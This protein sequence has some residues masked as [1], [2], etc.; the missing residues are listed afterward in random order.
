MLDEEVQSLALAALF[1]PRMQA[2]QETAYVIR[3]VLFLIPIFVLSVISVALL[4]IRTITRP[5]QVLMRGTQAVS[6]GDLMYRVETL[7]QD[8]FGE[9]AVHFN[10]MV[11]ELQATTVSKA[12]LQESE[13]KLHETV[14]ELRQEITARERTEAERAQLQ[15]SLRRSEIMAAM[16]SLVA[17]VAHE[18]RNPLFAISSTLDAFEVR[19][20]ARQEYQR[21]SSVFRTEVQRLT[22]LMQALL[23]YGK[24]PKLD[25]V[26]DAPGEAYAQAL[27]SCTPLATRMNVHIVSPA[28]TDSRLIRMDRQ[29]L[30]QV[31]QNLMENAIQHSL[32][33]GCIVVEATE[34]P[35]DGRDWISYAIKDSGPGFNPEDLP[36]VFEPF[37]TRRRGGTGLGMSIV[38]R[39]VEEHGGSIVAGN[40]PEGGAVIVVRFALIQQTVMEGRD[41][42]AHHGTEQNLSG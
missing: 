6:R 23:E 12:L 32:S 13:A 27:R 39:I 26:S 30:V 10:R 20:A 8:E 25:L 24:P 31:F 7:G 4:L 16:G 40:R 17:G 28:G 42:G 3:M 11:A 29:R 33:G 9:L 1:A 37:F 2:D 34:V 18:V 22:T 41:Q 5:V 36:R 15:A 14:G 21:Y 38:Q 35:L 19:F